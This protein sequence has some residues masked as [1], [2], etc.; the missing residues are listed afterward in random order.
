MVYKHTSKLMAVCEHKT[1]EMTI[2]K[3]MKL[4][5]T[6]SPIFDHF[7]FTIYGHG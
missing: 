6:I 2:V 5:I 3:I 7:N 1:A 4:S